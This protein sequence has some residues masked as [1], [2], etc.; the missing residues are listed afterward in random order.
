MLAYHGGAM[1]R[2]TREYQAFTSLVD[3]LLKV[4]KEELD[5]RILAYKAEADKNPNKR[6]PKPKKRRVSASASRD[7]VG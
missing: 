3:R 5:R 1:A 7:T 4:P 6:G 2:P